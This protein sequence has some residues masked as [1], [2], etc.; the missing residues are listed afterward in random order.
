MIQKHIYILT[1][2][3]PLK[4][5]TGILQKVPGWLTPVGVAL[6]VVMVAIAAI[7]MQTGQEGMSKG[8]KML[9]GALI[10]LAVLLAAGTIV[11]VISQAAGGPAPS[12]T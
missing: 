10:G 6:A 12:L 3:N 4:D 1:A 7:M 9:I 11:T 8:K 5:I 2:D